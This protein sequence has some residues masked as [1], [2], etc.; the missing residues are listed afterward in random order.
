MLRETNQQNHQGASSGRES[1]RQI[2]LST[3]K[4]SS[5]TLRD[6]DRDESGLWTLTAFQQRSALRYRRDPYL[7]TRA[8]RN[9]AYASCALNN[10]EVS[11]LARGQCAS[12]P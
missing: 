1:V 7:A 9:L 11:D 3:P 12:Y 5:Q 10:L 6:R 4:P 8:L 2:Q